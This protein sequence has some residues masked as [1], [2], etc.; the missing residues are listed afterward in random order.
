[1]FPHR[2][3]AVLLVDIEAIDELKLDRLKLHEIIIDF[4]NVIYASVEPILLEKRLGRPFKI[5]DGKHRIHAARRKNK[6]LIPA[7]FMD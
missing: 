3:E 5:L 7:I 2:V 4:E 6:K 1:M